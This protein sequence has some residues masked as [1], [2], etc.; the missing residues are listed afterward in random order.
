MLSAGCRRDF[1]KLMQKHRVVLRFGCKFHETPQH[2]LTPADRCKFDC[3][4]SCGLMHRHMPPGY[5]GSL[6]TG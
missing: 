2:R 5:H 6:I 1:Y 4:V 3:A